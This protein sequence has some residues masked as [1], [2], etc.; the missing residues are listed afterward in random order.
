M[1]GEAKKQKERERERKAGSVRAGKRD[2]NFGAGVGYS[3][4]LTVGLCVSG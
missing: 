3:V 2:I 1:P 4:G